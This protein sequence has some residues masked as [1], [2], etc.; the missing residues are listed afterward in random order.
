[1]PKPQVESAGT[2]VVTVTVDVEEL[3][4]GFGS[5]VAEETRAVFATGPSEPVLR[6][7]S[8]TVAELLAAMVP[9]EQMT[10]FVPEQEP[11]DGVAETNVVPA[12]RTSVTFTLTAG[13]G[14]AFATVRL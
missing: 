6:T 2:L 5:V 14:P 11:T 7:M 13:L 3:L 8:T 9:R 1:M 4:A 12:G 10:V